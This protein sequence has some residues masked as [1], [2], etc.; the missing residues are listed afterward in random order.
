MKRTL[1]VF[2]ISLV[3]IMSQAQTLDT[4]SVGSFGAALN[5]SFN[6]ELYTFQVTPTLMYN[7]GKNQFGLGVGFNPIDRI[8]QTIVSG[9]LSY[10]HFP[11]GSNNKFNL[12]LMTRLSL[13]YNKRNTYYPATYNFLL[14]DGGYGLQVKLFEGAYLGTNISLGT[15]SFNKKSENPYEGFRSMKL[16]DEIGLVLS[17]Q[18]HLSYQF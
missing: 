2:A 5:T 6:G 16:W 7:K 3:S 14:L 10:K 12:Y 8:D 13:M 4:A 15:F 11:N 9:E 18:F 1:L 17:S